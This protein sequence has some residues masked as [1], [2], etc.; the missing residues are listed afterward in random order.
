MSITYT[1]VA[2]F[3]REVALVR[4]VGFY[5]LRIIYLRQGMTRLVII[6]HSERTKL[7][8]VI[9]MNISAILDTSNNFSCK[10]RI[11]KK[12]GKRWESWREIINYHWIVSW[13]TSTN[14]RRWFHVVFW[15]WYGITVW[16]V[17]VH[18][19]ARN[20]YYIFLSLLFAI[21]LLLLFIKTFPSRAR[22]N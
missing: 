3:I 15:V 22:Y 8:N 21:R 20:E 16:I 10:L 4:L 13:R 9:W 19:C 18:V 7:E 11:Q 5:F 17:C 6:A 12:N 14:W 2:Y 1:L